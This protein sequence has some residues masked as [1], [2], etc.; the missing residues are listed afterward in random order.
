[1]SLSYGS[2]IFAG[3][4]YFAPTSDAWDPVAAGPVRAVGPRGIP[5]NAGSVGLEDATDEG[6]SA[7]SLLDPRSSMVPW[8]VGG[9]VIAILWLHFVHF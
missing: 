9:G 5:I 3:Q 2:E 4:R 6:G 7:R 8:L 1:M